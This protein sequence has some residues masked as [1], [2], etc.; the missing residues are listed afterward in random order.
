MKPS[1]GC[2]D[3]IKSFEGC[4]LSAYVDPASGGL[5]ITIGWGST[6]NRKGKPFKLGNTVSQYEADCLLEGEINEKALGLSKLLGKKVLTQNQFDS[7]VCFSY[8]AGLGALSTSTLLK[9]VLISP[10][11]P[12]LKDEFLKWDKADGTH[13]HKDDDKDGLIDEPGEKQVMKGLYNRR[14]TEWN[15]FNKKP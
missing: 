6:L 7:L 10:N 8:N 9:K 3:I 15:L 4:N 12:T 11:D 14:L 5:P 13:N 2:S 1:K